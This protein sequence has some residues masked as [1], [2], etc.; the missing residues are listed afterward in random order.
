MKKLGLCLSAALLLAISFVEHSSAQN[1]T[2]STPTVSDAPRVYRTTRTRVAI[3]RSI[4]VD[5]DEEVLE[6][7]VVVGGSL[8]VEGRIREGLVVVGGNVTL[9]PQADVRG[10]VV[11]VGG[12]LTRAEGSQLRGSVSDISF[13]DWRPWTIAGLWFPTVHIGDFGRWLTVFGTVFRISL[14]AVFI[15]FLLLVARAPVAR[16]GRAAAAEPGRAF[17]AG[18]AAEILFIPA[19]VIV[20][21]GLIITLIGIPLLF[22]FLPL[23]ILIGF[24]ALLLGFTA[25]TCRVGEW[26]QDRLGWQSHSALISATLGL[27]VVVGPTFVARM[28]GLANWPFGLFSVTMLTVGVLIEFVV[29]TMGLGATLMTGFGRW[30]TVPPPLPSGPPPVIVAQGA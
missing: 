12:T 13:G 9:G 28:F 26:L 6:A 17:L 4:A 25:I 3:G 16:I 21:I 23:A 24:V 18:L 2:V 7:V 19:L 10:D 1:A 29:W 5:R 15:A 8:R 27:L 22:V 30:S 20:S 14:L 11:V